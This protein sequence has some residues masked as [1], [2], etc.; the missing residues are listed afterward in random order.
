MSHHHG[1][2]VPRIHQTLDAGIR[3]TLTDYRLAKGRIFCARGCQDCCTLA[4]HATLPEII[5][6]AA[7]SSAEDSRR[8]EDYRE[9]L[10]TIL[11]EAVDFKTFLRL[12]RDRLGSCPF[13]DASGC[14]R[15]YPQRP[16]ACR[17]LLSTRN[18]AWCAADFSKLHPAEKEAFRS[19]A[20]ACKGR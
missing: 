13:L 9:R 19:V 16:L 15:I 6:V 11:P 7:V 17:A 4:V 10:L 8:L 2:D 12:H 5:P 3:Q 1:S 14:C 18:S 20:T